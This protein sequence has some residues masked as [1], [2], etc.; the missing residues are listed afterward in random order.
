M[1]FTLDGSAVR[2][3]L[4]AEAL[5]GPEW[6][7]T[8]GFQTRLAVCFGFGPANNVQYIE[9]VDMTPG[10]F[11]RADLEFLVDDIEGCIIVAHNARY[12]LDLLNGV[13]L[14]HKLPM[15]P[16]LRYLDTMNTLK[17][18]KAFR[19]TLSA[20]CA[21][22]GV[23]LKTGSP[24]WR[25]VLQRK[26]EAWAEMEEYNKNDVVCTLELADAYAASGLPCPIKTWR[27]RKSS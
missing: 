23:T 19:N 10:V 27:P 14:D 4:D 20:R 2:I 9:A 6:I 8:H 18:G 12:D 7:D 26:P 21:A 24:D 25:A 16:E 13:L 5:S 1:K 11:H 17:N 22:Y 15:L 3:G